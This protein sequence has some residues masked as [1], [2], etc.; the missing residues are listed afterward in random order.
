MA[1]IS[2]STVSATIR[3]R[4]GFPIWAGFKASVSA[5]LRDQKI[6]AWLLLWRIL[7]SRCGNES[8]AN[9]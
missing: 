8:Y 6:V 4:S 1:A 5:A 2:D 3:L 7:E 9:M